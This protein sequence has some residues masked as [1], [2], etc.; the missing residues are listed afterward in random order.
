MKHFLSILCSLLFLGFNQ[1]NAQDY[2]PGKPTNE[3]S[4]RLAS[5]VAFLQAQEHIPKAPQTIQSPNAASLGNYGEINVSPYTGKPQVN[6]DLQTV[7]DGNVNI[8]I[9]LLYDASG[10]KPDLHPGWVGLNFNLSTNYSIVRTIKDGPDDCPYFDSRGQRGYL[11]G[12]PL[13]N[14]ASWNTPAGIREIA[15]N[16]GGRYDSEPDEYSFTLPDLSGKFV[17]GH[18]GFWKVLCDRPVKVEIAGSTPTV[19]PPFTP[20]SFTG[21]PWYTGGSASTYMG[22]LAGFTIT[23]EFGTKYEFGGGNTA[24]MEYSMAFFN[25][26]KD[27]WICNAWYLKSITRKTGSVVDFT[28]QRG[29]FVAQM[30][31]SVY[32]KS[33]RINGGAWFGCSNWS[34]LIGNYGAF[35]GKLIS[36]IYLTEISASN[37]KVKFISTVSRE[38]SYTEDIFSTYVNENINHNI[39]KL[40]FLTYLY[41]CFYPV[42][43]GSG[44]CSTTITLANLLTK[45]KWRKLDRIQIQNGAGT[46]IKEFDF[47]YNNVA[48]ERLMLQKVQEKS[49]DTSKVVPPYEFTYFTDSGLS[50]PGYSKSHTDHWGFNNGLVINT[51][52]DFNAVGSYGTTFRGPA[53]DARY[54]KL[55]SLTSIK[56]P[57][58][59][60]TKFIM[61]PHLYAKEVKLK[62]WDGEDSFASNQRAGGLRIKEV[63]SYDNVTQPVVSKKYYYLAAFNPASPDTSSTALSSGILGGKAQYYFPNYMP[64]P[65]DA[66]ISVEEEIFST[67]SVLPASENSMGSH[68]GYSQV[69]ESSSTEGWIIH[70]FSNFDNGYRDDA[71]SGYLQTSNTPYQPYHSKEFMRGKSLSQLRYFKNGNIASETTNY[72]NL[73]GNLSEYSARSVKTS[74]EGLCNT[75]NRIYEGTAYLIDARK[76]LIST[77]NNYIYD[78]DNV[79]AIAS[80]VKSYTYWP[81]GQIYIS[82]QSDSKSR[83]IK[84][85]YKYPHNFSDATSIAMTTANIISVP[86]EVI[87]Y[88]GTEA[89]P[90]VIKT[91]T[92]IF[93]PVTPYLPQ[94]VETKLGATGPSIT[95]LE[96]LSYDSR[97]NLLTY[98]EKNGITS[99]LEYFGTGDIGKVDMVKKRTIADGASIS[100]STSY[101]Y[102]PLVGIQ[103][104]TDPNAKTIGYDYDDFN[105][106]QTIKN[107]SG[108]ARASYCYNYAGQV[109]DC[110]AVNPTGIISAYALSL[111]SDVNSPDLKPQLTITPG[112]FTNGKVIE[113][114]VNVL[115]V[116]GILPTNGSEI[117]V[118]VA[119]NSLFT[120]FTWNPA[121][122]TSSGGQSVQNSI[123]APS[124]DANYYIFK[125]S[126][127]IPKSTTRRLV[128]HLTGSVLPGTSGSFAIPVSLVPGSGGELNYLNNASSTVIQI[129]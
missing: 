107:A 63:H 128:F 73:I 56:F 116:G 106:L 45:L 44:N 84:T 1:I 108:Q 27:T 115:E 16:Y 69:V 43:I 13:L 51:S 111:L 82:E 53:A 123:W 78:Q 125:T 100:Q 41:D 36:P 9:S 121:I 94:K 48:N 6:V 83:N 62:R 124:E 24:Y 81:N 15:D 90:S 28:Y 93:N 21:N 57:T 34:S 122:T 118:R 102:K 88:T 19:Y 50:L 64:L 74:L 77:E 70:K 46:T 71:P 49:G 61:E 75:D 101:D 39:Y 109:V 85:R 67:Q 4:A 11:F 112:S 17:L 29:D 127:V 91:Q 22:H 126:S 40:S 58:G 110:A 66:S 54:L 52:T 92:V 20:P 59:G 89:D 33:A 47:T 23:D 30:Y 37:F 95:D 38:L 96:F 117:T 103:S 5:T 32:N 18:D 129:F 65:D 105:R 98:K 104:I 31:F 55:N 42:D 72:F 86:R 119:K 113:F 87:Q 68:I 3:D 76:F 60:V 26:G 120:N 8:P 97:G 2:K 25:Q 12:R 35:N 99:K 10:V 14:V 114:M 80:S 79:S 7:S